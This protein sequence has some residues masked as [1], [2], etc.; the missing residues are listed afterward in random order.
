MFRVVYRLGLVGFRGGV[1]IVVVGI[2]LAE[3]GV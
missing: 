3:F 1:I 2:L